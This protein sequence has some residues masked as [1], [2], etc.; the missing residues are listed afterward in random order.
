MNS[1]EHEEIQNLLKEIFSNVNNWLAF[2][3]GKN[4]ALVAFNIACLSIIW[5]IEKN[6]GGE[7]MI[8]IVYGGM[9]IST[10]MALVSFIPQ[11]NKKIK[12]KGIPL[13]NDS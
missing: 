6:I 12:N 8:Y 3:E 13:K 5:D 9:L 1:K 4:A 7:V 2:A 10:I 11:M